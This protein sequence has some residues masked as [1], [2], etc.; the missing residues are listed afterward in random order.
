MWEGMGRIFFWRDGEGA[1]GHH[2]LL[3]TKMET[4]EDSTR[5]Q[6]IVM[7]LFCIVG[8]DGLYLDNKIKKKK[9]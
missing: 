2:V 3:G 9:C 4:D 1:R 7:E 6:F 5:F 8:F